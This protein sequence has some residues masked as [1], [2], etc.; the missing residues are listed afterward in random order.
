MTQAET[1]EL[2]YQWLALCVLVLFVVCLITVIVQGWRYYR[3][4]KPRKRG[5]TYRKR[6]PTEQHASYFGTAKRINDE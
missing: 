3:D 4:N 6:W 2:Y 5:A 1:V